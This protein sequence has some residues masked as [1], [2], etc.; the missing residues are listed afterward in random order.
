MIFKKIK[1]HM[2]PLLALFILT[3]IFLFYFFNINLPSH[4]ISTYYLPS[5][6]TL[7][8][9]AIEYGDFWPLW[10]PYGFGG[11]PYLMK[12]IPGLDSLLGILLLTIPS[13]IIAV[14]LTYVLLFLISGISMYFLMIYLKVDKKFAFISALIYILNGHM[15]KLLSWGW[16][17]T[18]GG[19]ALLPLAFLFGMKSVK[20]KQ[21]VKN[22]IIMGIIL[23]ILFRL[24]P[25]MKVTMWVG[26]LFGLY[27]IFNTITKFSK[28]KLVKTVLVASLIIFIF[29]G[30]SA[31][32]IIPNM[33]FIKVTSRAET[34]WQ[35]ASGRQL[36]YKDAFNRI[37]EPIYKG[38]PKVQREGTGD[39]IG[40]IALLLVFFAIYKKYKNKKVLFFSLGAL[41]SL[42]VATNTFKLYYLLWSFVPFFKSLRYMDRS[43]F[44]FVFCCS[45]LAGIGAKELIQ[46]IK[47]KKIGYIILIGLIILNLG[48]FNYSHYTDKNPK[49]WL[50]AEE[51]IKNNYIL[52]NISN[53][54]GTFRIQTWETRGIDWGTDFYNVPLKL[55]HLYRY[56]PMWYP[57]YMNV[58]LSV[59]FNN[60]AM[61]WG[62][63]NLKYLTSQE[64]LN[65]SGFKLVK[66]FKNCTVCYPEKPLWAKAWGPYLYENELFLPRAYVVDNSILV[67]GEDESVKQTTYGLMLN[68]K[69]NPANTVMI[70]GK[71]NINNYEIE[72]LKK[73]SAIFLVKDSIDQNSI[74]KLEQYVNSGGIL[75]PEITKN[76]NSVS[77]EEINNLFNSFKGELKPIQDSNIIMHSFDKREIKLN[78]EK[79]FLVYSEKFSEFDGWT[80]KGKNKKQLPLLNANGIV[81]AVY[82]N[83]NENNLVFEYKP[84]TYIAG[85]IITLITISLI[86]IYLIF[87]LLKKQKRNF[88]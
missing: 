51:A 81:S 3:F 55:E 72:E 84:G 23:A 39:H 71:T 57:P 64:E 9:S 12:P 7:K 76:K 35:K 10:T 45:I 36:S 4:D 80:V 88:K 58:Y 42:F 85:L 62:I 26:I 79:N 70:R 17:T 6:E 48:V 32:R 49:G 87:R 33:T 74:F 28:E 15:A 60:P 11:S 67:V 68:P 22:S 18:L 63:L 41:F 21:W 61:F 27:L 47:Y 40:I 44:L 19:Y 75:L 73:Y 34:S 38:M 20:E 8:T 25:D 31:Q 24:N 1:A 59:S 66:K 77:E 29:F 53:T 65:I 54:P 69:F 52:Q 14:K 50:N 56:D 86:I 30:L 82:L 78:G 46:K 13:T 43:L 2:L 5:A 83:G 37:I 16:L